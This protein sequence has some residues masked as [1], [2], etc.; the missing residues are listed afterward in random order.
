MNEP[1]ATRELVGLQSD[2]QRFP[3]TI[4]VGTPYSLHDSN[5]TWRCPVSITPLGHRQ[6]EIGGFD[7]LQRT[8]LCVTERA[9]DYRHRSGRRHVLRAESRR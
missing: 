7:S 9:T 5:D 3:I 8:E 6:F 1:I 2:G 4:I